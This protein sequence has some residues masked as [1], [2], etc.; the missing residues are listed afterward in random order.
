MAGNSPL[1]YWDSCLFIAWLKDEQRKTGDMDGVREVIEQA[2]R[3]EVKLITSVLTLTEVLSS[4]IPIGIDTL[5]ANLLKRISK[6]G[7][8]IKI[9]TLA[10]DLR[11]FY[12]QK[13]VEHERKILSTPDALHLATAILCRADEFHTFDESNSRNSLGLLPLT[14]NV[15]DHNLTICKPI[16]RNPELDLRRSPRAGS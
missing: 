12:V 7:V 13:A 14:G 1:Y 9:A 16:A 3:R 2:K 4:Q 15:A 5:F 8:D 10:H 6:Q 11:D